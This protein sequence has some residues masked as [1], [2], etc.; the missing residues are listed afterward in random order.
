M[1]VRVIKVGGS[2]LDWP[3]LPAVLRG[4]LADQP[5]AFNVLVSGGGA[6]ADVVRQA[7]QNFSLSEETTH[8]LCIDGLSVSARI[9]AAVIPEVRLVS[10]YDRLRAEMTA[11]NTGS[12]V[13]DPREFLRDHELHLPGHV[14]PHNWSVTSDSIAARLAEVLPADELVLLKS[15]DSPANSLAELAAAGY[16]DQHFPMIE[17]G[18]ASPRFVNLRKYIETSALALHLGVKLR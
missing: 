10:T 8:W 14:L 3:L 12:I 11:P 13:F 16:V 7:D 2:L 9:V 17:L 1:I 18:T 6:L 15:C 5:P 4:W